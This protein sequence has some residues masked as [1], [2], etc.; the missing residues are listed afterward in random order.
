MLLSVYCRVM[1]LSISNKPSKSCLWIV[2]WKLSQEGICMYHFDFFFM[3]IDMETKK[4]TENLLML[5]AIIPKACKK[6]SK[7]GKI[8]VFKKNLLL[9]FMNF[10]TI[11]IERFAGI[12]VVIAGTETF[13]YFTCSFILK[14]VNILVLLF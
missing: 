11:N 8:Q 9:A 13:Y 7:N 5:N 6:W 4:Q 12:N 1:M 14:V 2:W 10:L 3:Q